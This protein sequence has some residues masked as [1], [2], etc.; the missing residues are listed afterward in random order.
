MIAAC[1]QRARQDGAEP[2][3]RQQIGDLIGR[4]K[5]VISR[6]ITRNSGPDGSYHAPLAH[7]AATHRRARPKSFR[8]IENPHLC[9]R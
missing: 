6:E 8:F 4:D 2:I 3:T 7:L 9:R 1:L 5:S